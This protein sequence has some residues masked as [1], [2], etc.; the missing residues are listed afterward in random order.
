MKKY[1]ALLLLS[2]CANIWAQ[3]SVSTLLQ[4]G[5]YR[6]A[7]SFSIFEK[8]DNLLLMVSFVS[9]TNSIPDDPQIQFRFFD[10]TVLILNGINKKNETTREGGWLIKE[11]YHNCVAEFPITQEEV[12][13]LKI[14]IK[15]IRMTTIPNII[16]REYKKDKVGEKLYQQYKKSKF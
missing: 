13:R 4:Y 14:G 2:I 6:T 1:L 9:D 12:E 16:E 10:E 11:N 3:N 15:K 8:N 5:C 7:V